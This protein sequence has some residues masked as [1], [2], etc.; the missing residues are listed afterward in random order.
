MIGSCGDVVC[1]GGTTND[2]ISV[3]MFAVGGGL[4]IGLSSL[5]VGSHTSLGR[6]RWC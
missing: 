5:L 4:T 1:K 2:S 6:P 3:V